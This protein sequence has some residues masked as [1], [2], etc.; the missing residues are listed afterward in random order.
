MKIL[1]IL[2]V[3]ATWGGGRVHLDLFVRIPF[4]ETTKKSR[5]TNTKEPYDGE[6]ERA[7]EIFMGATCSINQPQLPS[8]ST[9]P[10]TDLGKVVPVYAVEGRSR[11]GK[12][13]KDNKESVGVY[14]P[15]RT[16]DGEKQKEV[17]QVRTG[18]G[19]TSSDLYFVH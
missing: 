16:S 3:L 2:T 7:L 4:H 15:D 18:P 14:I 10:G 19:N 11:S 12:I 9:P 1:Y 6:S 5:A 17:Y 8:E 13:Y